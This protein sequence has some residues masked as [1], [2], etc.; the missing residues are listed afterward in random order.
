MAQFCTAPTG[1]PGRF[2]WS[3]IPPPLTERISEENLYSVEIY[4]FFLVFPSESR[5]S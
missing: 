5:L 4:Q 3:I 1:P 2:A